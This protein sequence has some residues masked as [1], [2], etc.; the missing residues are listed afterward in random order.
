MPASRMP[1]DPPKVRMKN[2]IAPVAPAAAA[3]CPSKVSWAMGDM[4]IP[5]KKARRLDTPIT[6]CHGV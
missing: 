1:T 4:H 3:G 2:F 5:A 6:H